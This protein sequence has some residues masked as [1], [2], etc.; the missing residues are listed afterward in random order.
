M[1]TMHVHPRQTDEQT[2]IRT[3]EHHG[4]STTI[5]STNP[6]GLLCV[7]VNAGLVRVAY[8]ALYLGC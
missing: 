1:I 7:C 8:I 5:R 2:G 6:S 3:D 4:N